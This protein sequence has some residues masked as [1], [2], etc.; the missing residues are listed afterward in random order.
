MQTSY[1]ARQWQPRAATNS[2][3]PKQGS[4]CLSVIHKPE[5]SGAPL[6][7]DI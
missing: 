3:A 4:G 2:A 6:T 7:N 5:K 1:D